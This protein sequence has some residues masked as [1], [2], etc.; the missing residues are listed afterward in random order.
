MNN[1][2]TD[3]NPLSLGV[4]WNFDGLMTQESQISTNTIR[5]D[6]LFFD[7]PESRP[8]ENRKD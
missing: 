1:L 4:K 3:H 7:I 2:Q 6:D 5:K 8:E